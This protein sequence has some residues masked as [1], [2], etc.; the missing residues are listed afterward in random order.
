MLRGLFPL[1]SFCIVDF[2]YGQFLIPYQ[3]CCVRNR[4]FIF[5]FLI[6]IMDYYIVISPQ[7]LTINTGPQLFAILQ[8]MR[9]PLEKIFRTQHKNYSYCQIGSIITFP[10]CVK[11]KR[12]LLKKHLLQIF[13]NSY[14]PSAQP[15]EVRFFFLTPPLIPPPTPKRDFLTTQ[16]FAFKGQ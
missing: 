1:R 7:I 12:D 5:L 14:R 11:C 4:F 13:G 6:C 2:V 16:Y 8:K 10:S 9:P 15:R 3:P